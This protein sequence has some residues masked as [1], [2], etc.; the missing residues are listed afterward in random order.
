LQAVEATR[1]LRANG[2]TLAGGHAA[3][4]FD[5]ALLV[6]SDRTAA[7]GPDGVYHHEVADRCG[8]AQAAGHRVRIGKQFREAF[9]LFKGPNNGGAAVALA[10]DQARHFFAAEPAQ[11]PHLGE[12]L[13][14]T[15]QARA[16]AG[17]VEDHVRESPAEL[18]G[19]FEAHR[20][21]A[22]QAVRLL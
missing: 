11:F 20:L 16:A 22:L 2:D 13:P 12:R 19:E 5:D 21:L 7:A 18:L 4:P 17:R 6:A 10:T 9:A 14:H 8:H 3:H 15:D 1:G